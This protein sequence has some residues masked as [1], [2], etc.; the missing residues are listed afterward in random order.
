MSE[1]T[2]SNFLMVAAAVLVVTTFTLISGLVEPTVNKVFE[3]FDNLLNVQ[4]TETV[5]Q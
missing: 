5:N 4:V 2:S 1:V 3:H